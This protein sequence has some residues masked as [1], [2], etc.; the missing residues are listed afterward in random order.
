MSQLSVEQ[1]ALR[2]GPHSVIN[3]LSFTLNKGEIGCLLGGSGC[4]KTSVLRAIAGFEPLAGGRIQ[5]GDIAISQPGHAVPPHLR[6]IGMV[7]QDYA[8]F[9]HLS[10]TGNVGFGLRHL[11]RHAR[12]QRVAELLALT[13]LSDYACKYPYQ[14]SGG[15]QQRVA[16]ARALAPRPALLLL[17]EPFS[18]LDVDLRER[19]SRE[20]RQILKQEGTTAVLVTHEQREAFAM[21]DRVG[22]MMDGA[23]A[24]WATPYD[25][26]HHPASPAVAGFIGQGT[27][28]PGQVLSSGC[29]RL[30]LGE[31]CGNLPAQLLPGDAV[32]VLLR[33]DD[34]VYDPDATVRVQVIGKYFRGSEFDY[35]LALPSGQQMLM[36][37]SSQYRHEIGVQIGVRLALE[38]LVVFRL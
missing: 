24:Q 15:Q 30:E 27:L 32:T 31:Y 14:L 5:L 26:Y 29:I 28:L 10:V 18:N 17:D 21:A 36:Q 4:G 13:G 11:T 33:P 23:L 16:L 7:F 20:V 37:V 22:V 3:Q 1:I 38:R 9:P 34:V 6:R 2:Y 19:L 35:T 8:L 12:E 25:L